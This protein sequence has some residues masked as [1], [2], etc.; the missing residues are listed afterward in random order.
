MGI[1]ENYYNNIERLESFITLVNYTISMKAKTIL[2]MQ[3]EELLLGLI[4]N[5][6]RE[7]NVEYEK[8]AEDY[9]QKLNQIGIKSGFKY[10]DI[11]TLISKLESEEYEEKII[12]VANDV[13]ITREQSDHLY[14]SSLISLI[15]YFELL[16]NN[17]IKEYSEI[18]QYM[19]GINEKKLSYD[20]LLKL[21]SVDD[22]LNYIKDK[23][24]EKLMYMGFKNWMHFLDTK[25]GIKAELIKEKIEE[26]NEIINKR[27]LL[28]HNGGIINATFLKNV[29]N[30]L[31]LDM[32][33]GDRIII[34]EKY[35]L[36]SIELIKRYGTIIS[37][38]IWKSAEKKSELRES[39]LAQHSLKF[40]EKGEYLIAR[41]LLL[42]VE[43]EPCDEESK[44][45]SK[46]NYWQ[47]FKWNNEFDKVRKEIERFDFSAKSKKFQLCKLVLLDQHE[48]FID[49]IIDKGL[50]EGIT[51][52]S[53]NTW[54][55][56]RKLRKTKRFKELL[57]RLAEKKQNNN[58]E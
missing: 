22:A 38:H 13:K 49:E 52:E 36:D 58:R 34:E 11:E 39:F 51:T 4:V 43:K 32:K 30:K 27:H 1:I 2:E 31:I 16:I 19:L 54:P 28:I 56:F 44:L 57:K 8:I 55:L 42:F 50:P 41:D 47:T 35:I 21:G 15:T 3:H 33:I 10:N 20:E 37:L 29:D 26:V 18:N 14:E 45:I 7:D 5:I 48:E 6:Y 12:K 25:I 9:N 46:I 40:I 17:L 53:L 24:I 23:E